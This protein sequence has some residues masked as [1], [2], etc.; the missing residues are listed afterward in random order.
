MVQSDTLSR[1]P[2]FIPE[3]DTDNKNVTVLP[4]NLFFIQLLDIDLQRW[5]ANTHNHDD[6]V[7]KA[8]TTVLEQGP[9]TL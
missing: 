6:E 8:L 7:T 4:D 1:R 5:I 3:D 9:Y 2:D